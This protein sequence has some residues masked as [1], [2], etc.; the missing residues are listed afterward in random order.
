MS[1]A[2]SA[3]IE[4]EDLP[5]SLW[6]GGILYLPAHLAAAHKSR[7]V[8]MSMLDAYLAEPDKPHAVGGDSAEAATEH[9]V[10]RF[11]NSAARAE[12]VC[13]DPVGVNRPAKNLLLEQL[14]DGAVQV[15]DI[16]AGHG[17]GTLAIL[18]FIGAMRE[19]SKLPKLPLNVSIR[20]LDFSAEALVHYQ[21]VAASLGTWL[22]E[23]GINLSV[24]ASH[25]DMRMQGEV[26][27]ALDTYFDDARASGCKRFL[28]VLSAISG[29][30]PQAMSEMQA[31]FQEIASR[32]G[33]QPGGSWVWIEPPVSGKWL[34]TFITGIFYTLKK[35]KNKLMLI[36]GTFDLSAPTSPFPGFSSP[37]STFKWRDPHTLSDLLSHVRVLSASVEE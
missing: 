1:G 11:L 15:L 14:T 22:A 27:Q 10:W 3:S 21:E 19:E 16:A 8:A 4:S 7:L 23:Q 24:E 12:Y 13:A 35:I 6:D 17:A 37:A 36:G 2:V 29:V 5:P 25:V 31:S 26:S 34:Q 32:I 30:G 33:N 28:C 18:S 20:A 9:F